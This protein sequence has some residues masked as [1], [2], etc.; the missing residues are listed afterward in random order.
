MRE[1]VATEQVV[2]HVDTDFDDGTADDQKDWEPEEN[3]EGQESATFEATD[4]I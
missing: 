1:R 4:Y 2:T 3:K